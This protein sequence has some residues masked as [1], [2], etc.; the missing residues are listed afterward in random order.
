LRQALTETD[1]TSFRIYLDLSGFTEETHGFNGEAIVNGIA[2]YD[3]DDQERHL[4]RPLQLLS[5]CDYEVDGAFDEQGTFSGKVTLHRGGQEPIEVNLYNPLDPSG[6]EDN[7]GDVLVHLFVFDREERAIRQTIQRS[8]L[9]D[10]T[11]RK[12]RD[13][14][15]RSCGITIYRNGF[16]IRPYGDSDQDWLTLDSRRVQHPSLRIGHNQVSGIVLIDDEK[17]SGLIERSSREGL[18]INGAFHRLRHLLLSLFSEIIEPHR[19]A[20]RVKAGLDRPPDTSF[21]KAF[22]ASSVSWAER[23]VSHLDTEVRSEFLAE[24]SEQSHNMEKLITSL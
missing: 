21:K 23:F 13:L 3:T 1:K 14:L 22:E 7:C 17:R 4:V 5:A 10:L 20:F 18:E 16:R 11:V 24:V 15:D 8:G 6:E 19:H 2:A 9:V 12:A